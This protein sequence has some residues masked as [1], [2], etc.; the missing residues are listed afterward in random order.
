MDTDY[1]S[2][3]YTWFNVSFL[4]A[5]YQVI[6]DVSLF[7]ILSVVIIGGVFFELLT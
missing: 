3:L 1:P 6:G 5:S 2:S 7:F 4:V